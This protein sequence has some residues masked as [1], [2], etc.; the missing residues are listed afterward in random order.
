MLVVAKRQ[1][2]RRTNFSLDHDLDIHPG[3]RGNHG[4]YL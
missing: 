3:V 4:N 2:A 1:K